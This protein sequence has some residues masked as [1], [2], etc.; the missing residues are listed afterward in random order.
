MGRII[1]DLTLVT[2]DGREAMYSVYLIIE[3]SSAYAE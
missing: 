3:D 1:L 2:S